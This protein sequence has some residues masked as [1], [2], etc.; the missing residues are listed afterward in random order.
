MAV[1]HLLDRKATLRQAHEMLEVYPTL[2]KIVVDIR[3]RVL[4]GGGEMH[5][6]CESLLLAGGSEQDDLWGANWYPAE[7]RVEYESLINIRP[8]LG[9]RSMVIQSEIVRREVEAITRGLLEGV[10]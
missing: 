6:D 3:R 8:R 5:S 9:N 7:Q 1:I 4:A 2:V 10:Q